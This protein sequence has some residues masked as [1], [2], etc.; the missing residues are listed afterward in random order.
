MVWSPYWAPCR[1][2]LAYPWKPREG[3]LGRSPA[4]PVGTQA[5]QWG[6]A[7]LSQSPA[8]GLHSVALRAW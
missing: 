2:H 4:E 7:G 1:D 5:E 8:Q 3:H 6:E